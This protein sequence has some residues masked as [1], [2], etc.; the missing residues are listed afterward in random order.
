MD[1]MRKYNFID[2]N[3]AN[4]FMTSHSY[5]EEN[6]YWERGWGTHANGEERAIF[7]L[8]IDFKTIFLEKFFQENNHF[9]NKELK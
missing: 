3:I 9:I 5:R 1:K 2:K 7:R 4:S 6:N 8:E